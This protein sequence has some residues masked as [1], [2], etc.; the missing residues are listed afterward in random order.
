MERI[1]EEFE[2]CLGWTGGQTVKFSN[3]K[4]YSVKENQKI[5]L[6]NLLGGGL[7]RQEQKTKN[8]HVVDQWE[9]LDRV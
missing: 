4:G 7:C 6:E 5:R 9:W 2:M 1:F 8:E 3:K